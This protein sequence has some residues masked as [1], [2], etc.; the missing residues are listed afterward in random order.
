LDLILGFTIWFL[1]V[2]RIVEKWENR[3]VLLVVLP[4]EKYIVN[5][6]LIKSIIKPIF[7]VCD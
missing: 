1:A 4:V 2:E 3:W 6:V 5:G 7:L